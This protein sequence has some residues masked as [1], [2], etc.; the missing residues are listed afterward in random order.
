MARSPCPQRDRPDPEQD[1]RSAEHLRGQKRAPH[2]GAEHAWRAH[3]QLAADPRLPQR[4]H[5]ADHHSADR[6]GEGDP[7]IAR[8]LSA[9]Y[10]RGRARHFVRVYA[11]LQSECAAHG[12]GQDLSADLYKLGQVC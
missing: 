5:S 9:V 8:V 4:Q 6:S 1:P 2:R 12:S 10:A 7:A 11:E 3:P